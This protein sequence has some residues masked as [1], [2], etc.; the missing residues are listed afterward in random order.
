M[1]GLFVS[2]ALIISVITVWLVFFFKINADSNDVNYASIIVTNVGDISNN[3]NIYSDK[4]NT[5]PIEIFAQG[6]FK[7]YT[8]KFFIPRDTT[9]TIEA[10]GEAANYETNPFLFNS[11]DNDGI[12]LYFDMKDDKAPLFNPNGADRQY[13]ILWKSNEIKGNNCNKTGVDIV[14]LDPSLTSYVM[15]IKFPWK[16]L[17]FIVPK[18][19]A[20]LGFDIDIMDS[21]S[22]SE[23]GKLNWHNK[24]DENW[25]T[26]S[27][28]GTMILADKNTPKVDS[29]YIVA[30]KRSNRVKD[31]G[32]FSTQSQFYSCKH[33]TVGFIKDSLD[34]SGKFKAEWDENNLY[35]LVIVRDNIKTLANAIF[36]Y[37][38]LED[39]KG[40]VIWKMTSANLKYAGGALK[41]K[42]ASG[43][44]ALKKGFYFLKY[45]TD[46]SHSPG[47]WD[48]V[49]PN[50][51][52]YG[53]KAAYIK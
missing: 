29:N 27:D 10:V 13:R 3:S 38:W 1:I 49:P 33:I 40:N 26:T 34:L 28:Y 46:E 6:N 43:I 31:G 48:A 17:G 15:D 25:R 53:I 42:K 12:E 21:D 44:I 24:T 37:G 18:N 16:T 50:T 23:K 45:H 52:F 47:N 20:R 22:G 36:D 39:L 19:N 11:W 2:F 4:I 7:D 51:S 32:S 9:I 14:E 41:N 5:L 8:V 30:T 35:I